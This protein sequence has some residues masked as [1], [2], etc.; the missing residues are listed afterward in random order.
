[1]IPAIDRYHKWLDQH[2]P[3]R[4]CHTAQK[5][6]IEEMN[7][8]REAIELGNNLAVAHECVDV[9]LVICD[10]FHLGGA[11]LEIACANKIMA[12]MRK[13]EHGA[14]PK[15]DDPIQGGRP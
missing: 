8:L 1:M 13:V 15:P 11:S 5:K 2:F 6:L 12:V 9:V 4:S 7:E 3:K 10:L 14:W